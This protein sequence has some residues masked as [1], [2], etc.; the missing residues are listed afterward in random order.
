[1]KF[2]AQV[3]LSVFLTIIG[4]QSFS[5]VSYNPDI[6]SIY[7]SVFN[8]LDVRLK[9]MVNNPQNKIRGIVLLT[10]FKLDTLNKQDQKPQASLTILNDADSGKLLNYVPEKVLSPDIMVGRATLK[11]DTLTILIAPWFMSGE[12]ITNKVSGNAIFSTYR[13]WNKED[14]IFRAGNSD[15]DTQSLVI[16]AP[17]KITLSDRS[18]IPGKPFY[19]SAELITDEYSQLQVPDFKDHTMR[20][21]MAYS[22]VFKLITLKG[23]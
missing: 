15:I 1:M 10:S 23:E 7:D 18:F 3:F 13:L 5:Q 16:N 6:K 4:F 8:K 20:L 12:E 21:K 11:G 22:Y 19:G 9:R 2:A 14:K 17:V